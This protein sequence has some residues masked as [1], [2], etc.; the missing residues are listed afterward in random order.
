MC[1]ECGCGEQDGCGE[2]EEG[3]RRRG[4]GRRAE[5]AREKTVIV[6]R[7][8]RE[9]NDRV[10]HENWHA[11]VHQG[12]LC[13]NIMGAPG[14]G[15]TTLIE[16]LAAALGQE[17]IAVIQ[18]DLESDIDARRL[19]AAG[20]ASH[21]VNTH[22]GCHL[23]AAMIRD[24]LVAMTAPDGLLEDGMLA[25]KEYLFI[26][27]V[28]NLVCPAGVQLGQSVNIVVSATTEGSDKPLKYPPI[29]RGAEVVVITKHDLKDA[30]G[31]DENAYLADLRRVAPQAT[32]LTSAKGS[33]ASYD[34]LARFLRHEREHVLGH[35]HH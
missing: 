9:A 30:V 1:Q 23:N 16:G 22:S 25:G 7:S 26:E 2:K 11:L 29:F 34:A 13:V 24:A 5:I 8:V 10:A 19:Q 32:I 6:E 14:S 3:R 15:K 31:F 27:N 4:R 18:G 33:P 28:G 21:Q 17:K 35:H 12:L 20:I